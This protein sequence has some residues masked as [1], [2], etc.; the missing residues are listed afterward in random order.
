MCDLEIGKLL[1][2]PKFKVSNTSDPFSDCSIESDDSGMDGGVGDGEQVDNV[3]SI[4][5]E[6]L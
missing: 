5:S 1:E 4:T 2:V 6:F 3:F